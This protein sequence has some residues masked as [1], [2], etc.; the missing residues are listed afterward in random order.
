MH[1]LS[2]NEVGLPPHQMQTSFCGR[3]VT[4]EARVHRPA[5]VRLICLEFRVYAGR[6]GLS[7]LKAELRT[8][9]THRCSMDEVLPPHAW[10]LKAAIE[11]NRSRA[12]SAWTSMCPSAMPSSLRSRSSRSVRI[13][14]RYPVQANWDGVGAA[15]GLPQT[16][17]EAA[18]A[19]AVGGLEARGDGTRRVKLD[20]WAGHPLIRDAAE[21]GYQG[22]RDSS[23][24]GHGLGVVVAA[25][26]AA[27]DVAKTKVSDAILVLG[28]LAVVLI[29]AQGLERERGQVEPQGE[30]IERRDRDT[31]TVRRRGIDKALH[32][33]PASVRPRQQI[34][35]GLRARTKHGAGRLDPKLGPIRQDREHVTKPLLLRGNGLMHAQIEIHL[36]QLGVHGDIDS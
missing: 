31:C 35:F 18:G 4:G 3:A 16:Q 20:R 21:N 17:D 1:T 33:E 27:Q 14:L 13:A 7:R 26:V 10:P 12:D 32:R 5:V 25:G 30:G 28:D 23:A 6:T 8:F 9:S 34:P 2:K 11:W 36:V 22:C 29:V 24:P 15:G 19:V